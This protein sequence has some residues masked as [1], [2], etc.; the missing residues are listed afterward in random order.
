MIS[1]IICSASA[2]RIEHIRQNVAETIGVEHEII[3][4]T[5]AKELGGICKAYNTAAESA[6]FD[7]CCFVH[8]DVLF[9]TP[10]WGSKVLGH[11][12]ESPRL[13]LIGL[14]GGVYKSR[15]ISG[16][17]TGMK[18][19][20][21]C[22][23]IQGDAA[24]ARR[25]VYLHPQAGSS[26]PANVVPV[27]TLDG[28]WMCMRRK[29]WEQYPFDERNL[30]GFHFYDLDISLRVSQ[31]YTVAVV[32]DIDLV[33][34]S[35]GNF[36]AAWIDH[37]FRFHHEVNKAPLPVLADHGATPA[38]RAEQRVT[39]FWLN[40]LM[41]E[42]LSWETRIK[43]LR[44]TGAWKNLTLW[45]DVAKLLLYPVKRVLFERKK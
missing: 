41:K 43:W 45:P 31:Q 23:V 33:H 5:N 17:S 28:V 2:A 16:W 11:F 44:I 13:A 27:S 38:P 4:I 22:N 34:Y 19:Y 37:A 42:P 39:G 40:R 30:P 18:E 20:D 15:A 36:D 14:A 10:G 12:N 25:R 29:V 21:C 6:V 3:I 9:L 24:G 7:I 8:D 35:L 32:Y 1:V 26:N